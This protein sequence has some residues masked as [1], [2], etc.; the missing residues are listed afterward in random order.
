MSPHERGHIKKCFTLQKCPINH[1][2]LVKEEQICFYKL[3]ILTVF[4]RSGQI[5]SNAS[6]LQARHLIQGRSKKVL[7]RNK[8]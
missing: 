5:S 2:L 8:R 1:T 3:V 6:G 7:Q 4:T